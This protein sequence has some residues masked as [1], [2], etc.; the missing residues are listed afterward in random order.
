MIDRRLIFEAIDRERDFQDRKYGA[1]RL[2]DIPGW[3][4]IMEREILEVKESW[5]DGDITNATRE[6]L[7]V[8]SVGIAAL[9]QHGVVER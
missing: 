5:A 7:Q 9:E 2:H 4:I 3:I 6:L 8:I 1:G